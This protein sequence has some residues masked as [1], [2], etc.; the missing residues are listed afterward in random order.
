MNLIEA[1]KE[2]RK[3]LLI[4]DEPLKAY[5][6]LKE[7]SVPELKTELDNTYGMVRHAFEDEIYK[8]VYG[9]EGEIE[10]NDS[11]RIE[12]EYAILDA[13]RKY[14]RYEWIIDEVNKEKPKTFL[15]LGC[16]VGSLVTTIAN[17]GVESVGVDMTKTVIDTAK[18]RAKRYNLQDKVKFYKDDVR[19]FDKFKADVVVCF[20]VL[21]HIPDDRKFIEHL[22][23]LSTGWCYVSTPNGPYGNG[24][25][26]RGHWEWDGVEV[27]TR[28]H[29]RVYTKS[30]LLGLLNKCGCEIAFIEGMSDGLLWCKFRRKT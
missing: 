19:V 6:M 8:K 28:G 18:E 25:G 9:M 3:E 1:V 5:F 30:T 26:N 13:G 2:I 7:L 20:E 24:D 15:D 27:H 29:L 17:M 4:K 23:D 12:P 10:T 16:Y 21:E 11:E 22:C 14:T